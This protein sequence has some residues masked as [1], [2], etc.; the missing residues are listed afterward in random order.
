MNPI[1]EIEVLRSKQVED[2]IEDLLKNKVVKLIN[3]FKFDHTLIIAT[4]ETIYR[5]NFGK[6]DEVV[7]TL[8]T[9]KAIALLK[10]Q[11]RKKVL[12]AN[13]LVPEKIT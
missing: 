7:R 13:N 10:H 9:K 6:M 4:A 5:L 1:K 3:V 8:I 12:M 11:W 2:L